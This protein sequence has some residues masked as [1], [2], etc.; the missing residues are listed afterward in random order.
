M[1][2]IPYD[3]MQRWQAFWA[4]V[5]KTSTCWNWTAMTR[6]GY[7]M[8]R[9]KSGPRGTMG[10]HRFAYLH[11]IGFI[12]EGLEVDHLCRNRSCVNPQHFEIVPKR[13]NI[14]R[15]IGRAAMQARRT[16][17]PKGHPLEGENLQPSKLRGGHRHCRICYNEYHR[18]RQARL[19]H[20]QNV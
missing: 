15:G 14:L 16:H 7:G 18:E 20:G 13:I 11:C 19:H 2:N 5:E 4:K 12:P 3:D 10:A 8:F 9:F 17:C 6:D 1:P